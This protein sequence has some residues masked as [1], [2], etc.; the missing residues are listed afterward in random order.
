MLDDLTLEV[1]D[2][3]KAEKL[4]VARKPTVNRYLAAPN[5]ADGR[6]ATERRHPRFSEATV[7]NGLGKL[8]G[9]LISGLGD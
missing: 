9:A 3:I 7:Q 4:K 8:T 6:R 5:H 2:R 1:L